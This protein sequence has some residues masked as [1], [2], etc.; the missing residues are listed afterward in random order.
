MTNPTITRAI[1][2]V[3][4][5]CPRYWNYR[6]LSTPEK[7]AK[8]IE[9]C[10]WV[11]HR[12]VRELA[13]VSQERMRYRAVGDSPFHIKNLPLEGVEDEQEPESDPEPGELYRMERVDD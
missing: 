1:E 6:A 3:D 9:E 13:K 10:R 12:L 5:T 11:G 2:K 8:H 4:V 7:L